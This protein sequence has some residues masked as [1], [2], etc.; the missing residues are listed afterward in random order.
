MLK[1]IKPTLLVN[2]QTAIRNIQNMAHKA[3]LSKVNF[4]PHFKTHF[5]EEIGRWYQSAG[6][7][8][9]TVSSIDMATYFADKGWNDITIAFPVNI[10]QIDNLNDLA[11]R[12]TLNLVVE[13]VDTVL[14]LNQNLHH[15]VNIFIK[16]DTGY[17]RTGVF[18]KKTKAVRSILESIKSPHEFCGLLA[19]FGHT[20]QLRERHLIEQVYE[21]EVHQL[22]QL[23]IELD[24]PNSIIS[25]GDT[26]GCSIVDSFTNVDEIRPGN[27]VFYD[28]MQF[29]IGSCTWEDIAVCMA[30]PVVAIHPDTNEV[31]VHGGAVHFSKDRIKDHH[32]KTTFGQVVQLSD[33]AWGEPVNSTFVTSLSQEHGKIHAPDDFIQNL[34]IGSVIGIVPVHSCLTANLMRDYMTLG[35]ERIS[36]M[37]SK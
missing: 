34:K 20:Y 9:I 4:R 28:L 2:K 21:Q 29:H 22:N 16:I 15:A 8:N 32:G 24:H 37:N 12:I 19:H 5:S 11:A 18:W 26:P 27:F 25:I 23:R 35:G 6:V 14:F 3:E 13:S 10:L 31:V 7:T 1:I 36:T 30:C 17:G 33:H